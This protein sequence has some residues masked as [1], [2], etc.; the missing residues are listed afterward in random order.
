MKSKKK[1]PVINKAPHPTKTIKD[2]YKQSSSFTWSFQLIDFE[3]QFGWKNCASP[4]K[5][6]DV[7]AK[8]KAFELMSFQELSQQGSHGISLSQLSK[9]AKDRLKDLSLDDLDELYSFRISGRERFWC[10]RDNA[11]MKVLWWDPHHEICPSI[12]RH[13]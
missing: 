7:L 12:K 2:R 10:I 9:K 8:K 13:T 5:F 4:E 11:I 3:G 1:Q 6:Q